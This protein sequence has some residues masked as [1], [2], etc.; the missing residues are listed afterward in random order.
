MPKPTDTRTVT[1]A[2]MVEA[3]RLWTIDYREGRCRP[4][5]E[6]DAMPLEE[7]AAESALA[8]WD[9]LDVAQRGPA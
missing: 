2:E 4:E 8:T 5:E 6:I 3:Q 1:F 9:Y 7:V